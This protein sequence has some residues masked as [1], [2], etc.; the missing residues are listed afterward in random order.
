VR[1]PPSSDKAASEKQGPRQ[2]HIQLEDVDAWQLAEAGDVQGV[3]HY[4]NNLPDAS[5]DPLLVQ[6]ALAP[7]VPA[8]IFYSILFERFL[9][10]LLATAPSWRFWF[11]PFVLPSKCLCHC[12]LCFG[13][14]K[15]ALL[16]PLL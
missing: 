10:R 8:P 5:A 9:C 14:L 6:A 4:L 15:H 13:D 7:L 1:T 16:V 3:L 2:A 11:T 12:L